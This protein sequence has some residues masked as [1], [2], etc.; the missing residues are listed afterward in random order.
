MAQD[1]TSQTRARRFVPISASGTFSEVGGRIREAR[2]P[3]GA[4]IVSPTGH[5]QKSANN[6]IAGLA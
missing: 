2:L 1:L 5:C 6:D 3:E 4:D